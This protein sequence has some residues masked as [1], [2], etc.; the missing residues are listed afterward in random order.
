MC[1]K[2]E[3]VGNGTDGYCSTDC[4]ENKKHEVDSTSVESCADKDG[5]YEDGHDGDSSA[6]EVS[7]QP[8][9]NERPVGCGHGTDSCVYSVFGVL[10]DGQRGAS[11][12]EDE[13]LENTGR[14]EECR[15]ANSE[16]VGGP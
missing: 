1:E 4:Q 15:V 7:K 11:G 6:G 2:A 16:V 9:G 13:S 10:G 5:E 14:E 3:T 12:G 8:P